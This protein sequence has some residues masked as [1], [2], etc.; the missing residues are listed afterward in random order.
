[1]TL[2]REY[3][4]LRVTMEL[5]TPTGRFYRWGADDPVATNQPGDVRW[6]DTMPGGFERFDATLRRSASVDYRDLEPLSTITVRSVTG[7]IVG[8][9][10]LEREPRTSGDQLAITPSAVGWQAHL[11][12]NKTARMI[13]VDTD[14]SHWQGP[15]VLRVSNMQ[16]LGYDV[17]GAGTVSDATNGPA[18]LTKL[19]G[20]WGRAHVNEAWYFAK[21]MPI[22]LL[23]F[24]V[25]PTDAI[26]EGDTQWHWRAMLSSNDI[27]SD[28]DV[29]GE[30]RSGSRTGSVTATAT[31]RYWAVV[32]QYYDV[33]NTT[34]SLEYG[35]TWTCLAVY[36]NHGFT[37]QGA[38][39][40]TVA[41]GVLAS[42]VVEHAVR[43]WAPMLNLA[44]NGIST[45]TP[46]SLSLVPVA[47]LEPTSASEIIKAVT[48]YELQDWGVWDNKALHWGP[49]GSE[50]RA[51]RARIG[52]SQLMETGPQIDRVWNQV[53][54]AF[55]LPDRSSATI[56]PTGSGA[57]II[58][59]T[60]FDSDPENPANQ[61]GVTRCQNLSMGIASA[62]LAA[63]AGRTFLTQSKLLDRSGR[64]TITGIVEDAGGRPWPYHA[65]RSGDT[66]SF[67]DAHDTSPRRIVSSEKND[68][69]KTCTV[70]LDAP[71]DGL[72]ALLARL[73]LKTSAG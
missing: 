60:L 45:I 72:S 63:Q 70:E 51:W 58:D 24:A 20:P 10:R 41:P 73:E 15:G 33:G 37:L 4:P 12:D 49:R 53:V 40:A 25:T 17:D 67:I 9:Y 43:T 36:G 64:A 3:P 29:G 61:E 28:L 27:A 23:Y 52:P 55:Q 44:N 6:T 26:N 66:I 1:M 7:Q 62:D 35:V 54:V 19:T 16:D 31:N 14:L 65:V 18:L 57:Q 68:A 59:D 42:D 21:G 13:Y 39:S 47:F 38:G 11:E 71:P 46:S 22:S 5:E 56:G 32:Q 50:A 2:V 48:K 34:E 69:A 30:L 8:E